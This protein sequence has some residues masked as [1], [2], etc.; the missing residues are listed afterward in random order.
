M[1]YN[2]VFGIVVIAILAGAIVPIAIKKWRR[3]LCVPEGWTGLMYHHGLYVRR[4]NAGRHVFWGRGWAMT[5][6]DLRKAV[7]LVAGQD[8]LTSDSVGLK[9]SL[10]VTYQIT[11][12]VKAAHETQS[13]LNELYNTTQL[14]LR[15]VVNGVS[16]EALLNQ[17]LEIG[18]QLLSRVQPETAKIGINV[19]AVEV[20]DVMFPPDLK[21]AFADVLKAKQE[22]RAALERARGESVSLRNLANAA[23]VLDDN[24]ALMNLRL[25]QSLSAAQNTG[26]TLVLGVPGGFVPLKNGRTDVLPSKDE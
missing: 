16:V 14:A 24:P 19:L 12:P 21:R 25:I 11:E 2:M 20:K 8:V 18:T 6:I 5:L 17:R 4:N 7:M 26:N 9:L 15:A 22:G 10:V 23:R 3:V 13:W 1:N